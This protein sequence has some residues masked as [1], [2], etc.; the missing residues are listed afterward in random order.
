MK[1]DHL[2]KLG[3]NLEARGYPA[4]DCAVIEAWFSEKEEA[5]RYD[6][7]DAERVALVGNEDEE[8]EYESTVSCCGRQD[9]EIVGPSG[10]KYLVGFNHGH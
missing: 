5:F 7:M 8:E 9:E 1:I 10:A 4:A 3:L 2:S 6:C